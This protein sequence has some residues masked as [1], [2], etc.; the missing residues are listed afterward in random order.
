[1]SPAYFMSSNYITKL[2]VIYNRKCNALNIFSVKSGGRPTAIDGI[3]HYL[4]KHACR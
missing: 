2:S 3:L 1:M 4:Y